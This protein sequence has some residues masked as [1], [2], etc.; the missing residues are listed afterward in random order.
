MG[1]PGRGLE[2]ASQL[3][4]AVLGALSAP[5][6]KDIKTLPQRYHDALREAMRRLV[7]ADLLPARAG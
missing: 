5:R 3:V 7:A 2:G 1:L 4:E 6:G